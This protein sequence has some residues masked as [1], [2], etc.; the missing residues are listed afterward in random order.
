MIKIFFFL[1]AF[2]YSQYISIYSLHVDRMSGGT[3]DINT[4]QGKKI[5][6]VNIGTGSEYVSQLYDL[7]NFYQTHQ[8]SIVVIGFPSNDFGHE[9]NVDSL[10]EDVIRNTYHVSFPIAAISHVHGAQA[11]PVFQWLEHQSQNGSM[12]AIVQTDFQKF[13]LN[14]SGDLIGAFAP[15]VRIDSSEFLNVIQ[16]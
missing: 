3:I 15:Q 2:I 5:L 1:S 13:F 16:Y 12:N 4:Y 14:R 6:L 7:E 11:N 10:L 9:S 8:D